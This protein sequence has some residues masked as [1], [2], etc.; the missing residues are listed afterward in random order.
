VNYE[1]GLL[2]KLLNYLKTVNHP[3][4]AFQIV[5]AFFPHP[6]KFPFPLRVAGKAE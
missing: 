1:S 3:M 6:F 4:G 2:L 5:A